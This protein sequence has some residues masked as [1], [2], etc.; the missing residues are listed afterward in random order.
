ML[1]FL[2][3]KYLKIKTKNHQKSNPLYRYF[4]KFVLLP[5]SHLNNSNEIIEILILTG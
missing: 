1:I 5:L 3:Q 4:T 2:A